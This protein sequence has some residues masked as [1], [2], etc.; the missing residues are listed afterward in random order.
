MAYTTI[1]KL[2]DHFNTKLYNGTGSTQSIT[3]VGFQPDWV[4]HKYRGGAGGHNL[5]DAVRGATKRLRS[6][7]AGAEATNADTLTS[8]DSDGFSLGVDATG[9]GVNINGYNNVTWNWKAGNSSG[10]SNSNGSITS[11]VTA[12]ATAGFSIVKYTGSGS[13]SATVGHGLGVKPKSLIIKSMTNS[14]NWGFWIDTT[15]NGTADKRL[16]LN[17]D[18]ANYGNYFV[19]FQDNT[20]TL[21]SHNDGSWSGSGQN[22]IAYCFAEKTGYS[23][24]GSYIGNGNADGTFVY[25]GFKPSWILIKNSTDSS[26][27][28][29]IYDNKRLG[30]N[31]DNNMLRANLSNAEQT[32]DDIDIISNGFKLRRNSGA[33][34]TSHTY[35]YMAFGQSLVGSNNVP[36]TA[37]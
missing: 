13:G 30:Y 34:N 26:N 8:F 24:F 5:F 35:I 33:F 6:N 17:G 12:N 19:S 15:N 2:T 28:W 1:N 3:G 16:V 29:H 36:C 11:T 22:Y 18:A 27:N 21:P 32:D 10:S 23:K 37:R 25:T 9:D 14:E 7:S 4:W 20:F 31:V